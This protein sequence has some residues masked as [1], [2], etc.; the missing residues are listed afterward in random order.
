MWKSLCLFVTLS[1]VA[2]ASGGRPI[3]SDIG[4]L[5]KQYDGNVPGASLLVVHNGKSVVRR[6][7]GFAD[8]GAHIAA[9]PQT[10]YRLAS[11]TKQ[12]TATAILLLAQD[13]KLFLSDKISKYLPSLPKSDSSITLHHLLTHTSGLIDYEDLMA[14]GTTKQVHDADVLNLLESADSLHFAP[15]TKY[16]YSNT[17]YSLLALIVERVSGKSFADFLHDRIFIPLGMTNTVAH[18]DGFDTVPHRA[19]G[20]RLTDGSWTQRD[21]S[22]TSAVLGDGGIYSSIDD[23]AKWDAAQYDSRLLN[24]EWRRV[25][26]TPHTPTNVPGTSYGFGWEITGETIWHSGETT[27][28]RNV[29]VRYPAK[30]LTVVILTNRGAP[31]PHETALAVAKLFGGN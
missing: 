20:Y 30:K 1:T 21:Q 13:N 25:A 9:N 8:L 4:A 18:R 7:W 29:I 23:M 11:V 14:E 17:G 26:F 15:G 24:E 19:F 28:F 16:Q 6:S 22:S 12:F 5:M 3:D 31:E 2:C 27:G 10:N